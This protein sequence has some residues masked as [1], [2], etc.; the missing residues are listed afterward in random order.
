MEMKHCCI[1]FADH[2]HLRFILSTVA[3]VASL[4]VHSVIYVIPLLRN[5][6]P[7]QFT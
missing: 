4:A 5:M 7:S 3:F 6:A 2:V 1:Q